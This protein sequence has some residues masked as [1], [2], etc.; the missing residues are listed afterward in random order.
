MGG[1]LKGRPSARLFQ[2]PLL[3][4]AGGLTCG[5][6]EIGTKVKP[7]RQNEHDGTTNGSQQADNLLGKQEATIGDAPLEPLAPQDL[8]YVRIQTH[9]TEPMDRDRQAKAVWYW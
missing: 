1:T 9:G 3:V 7:T 8:A 5:A 4:R 2:G 6:T